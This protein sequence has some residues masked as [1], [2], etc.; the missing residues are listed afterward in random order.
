[1]CLS[2][3][4]LNDNR[5]VACGKC[6]ECKVKKSIEWSYRIMDE[7]SLHK[8]NCFL[9]LTYNDANLP[10]GASLERSDLTLFIKRLRKRVEP[11]KFK[12]FYAGEY[13]DLKGRPHYHVI[14]FGWSPPDKYF[15][16]KSRRGNDMFRSP[17]IESCWT[18]GFSSIE[19]IED[20][21]QAQYIALYLQ[22]KPTD[23]RVAPF[24]GM[25]NRGGGIGAGAVSDKIAIDGNVYKNGKYIRAPRYYRQ[26]LKK[27]G[28]DLSRKCLSIDDFDSVDSYMKQVAVRRERFFRRFPALDKLKG[29]V[30]DIYEYL[31]LTPR[32]CKIVA[33]KIKD[34][35]KKA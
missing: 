9:S 16:R 27:R 35:F 30:F 6:F 32:W 26:L 19:N 28:F 20:I 21:K 2:P 8:D 13:G 1:M 15:F 17:L 22:K 34:F 11:I 31:L 5:V 4:F 23:G 25:S 12:V 18:L 33:K 14:L 24:V 10:D 29:K 7:V 3:V